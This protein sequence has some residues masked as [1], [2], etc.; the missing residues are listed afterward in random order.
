M[1][2]AFQSTHMSG[3]PKATVYVL[4]T[5]VHGRS[6]F[7]RYPPI[8]PKA[9]LKTAYLSCSG[10]LSGMQPILHTTEEEQHVLR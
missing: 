2:P 6:Q 3:L 5:S 8:N 10:Q 7:F 1:A 9:V 4:R